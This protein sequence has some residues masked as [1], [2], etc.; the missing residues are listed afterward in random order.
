MT[1]KYKIFLIAKIEEVY[2]FVLV[3]MLDKNIKK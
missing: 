3:K 2:R 1:E